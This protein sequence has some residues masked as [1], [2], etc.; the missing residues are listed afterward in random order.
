MTN[1]ARIHSFQ[2]MGAVDGPGLR[3][4]V[5]FQGCPLRCA[6]CHNP[7]TWLADEGEEITLDALLE[8]VERFRP[9]IQETGGV[10]ASGGEP[11]LQAEFLAEF[12]AA[13]QERG[14]HTA[15]DTSGI[16]DLRK[17]RAVLAH[18]NL[19]IADVKFVKAQDFKTYCGG[20]VFQLF[21]FL[22]LCQEM[23]VPVWIR[24]VIVPALN[25]AP[26]HVD[27]LREA[28]AP[29]S[30]VERVE[31]LPFRKLCLPKYESLGIPF[32]FAD[33]EECPQE[34]ITRLSRRL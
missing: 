8:K 31:L 34:T 10:T 3:A 18:T 21:S 24:Q 2:S 5:F 23:N 27:A 32:P 13:L 20:N 12:F 30:N 17:A 22:D 33:R 15:L 4:V 11:L 14:F 7:D 1:T 26:M 19:V 28:V 9:Y 29:Y 16:G 6:Y 25:D